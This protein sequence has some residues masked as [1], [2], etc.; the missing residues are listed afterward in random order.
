MV[1]DLLASRRL[2]CDPQTPLIDPCQ[3]EKRKIKTFD[4][5]VLRACTVWSLKLALSA[6]SS[7][8]ATGLLEALIP[9]VFSASS[10]HRLLR[11]E[12][13]LH[14]VTT[15]GRWIVGEQA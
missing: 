9:D 4:R 6:F 7:I 3:G 1:E 10:T 11:I 12:V 13:L 15:M 8:L 2:V 14:L 5:V